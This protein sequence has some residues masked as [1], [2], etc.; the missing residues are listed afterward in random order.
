[1]NSTGLP[2]TP[3]QKGLFTRP[4]LIAALAVLLLFLV[5]AGIYTFY[6]GYDERSARQKELNLNV[7]ADSLYLSQSQYARQMDSLVLP[8]V[9]ARQTSGYFTHQGRRIAYHQYRLAAPI[10]NVIISHGFTERKEKYQ[11]MVYYCLKKGYQVF[12]LDHF[13]HG[14]SSRASSDSSMVH[15]SDYHVWVDDLQTFIAT[16][17]QPQTNG[18]KTILYGHSMGGGIA[19]RTLE[20]Y[21]QLVDG[22]ILNTPLF[23]LLVEGI[24]DFAGDPIART[25]VSLGKGS[26][27][28]LG[29][30]AFDQKKDKV[31]HPLIPATYCDEK[32]AYWHRYMLGLTQH[33]SFGASWATA[34]TL[35]DLTH[36]VVKRTNVEKITIPILL[37]QAERDG[38]VDPKGHFTFANRAR[39]L[40]FYRV[41]GAGHEI[42]LESNVYTIPYFQEVFR[43]MGNVKKRQ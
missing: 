36:S 21:P 1:M 10:G 14:R 29:A 15:C 33:P 18:Q 39:N 20:E 42:Y 3:N 11:E 31:Y 8:Y 40:E 26:T 30:R 9:K 17:V 27:Y 6:N 43:F 22:L 38:Y 25:L 28:A 32:G 37:F 24:P 19:A 12:I 2:P 41:K 7:P 35:M 4:Y 5:Y 23:K 13:G 34:S 16:I